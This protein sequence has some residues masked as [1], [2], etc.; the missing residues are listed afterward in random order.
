[1]LNDTNITEERFTP[2]SLHV[3]VFSIVFMGIDIVFSLLTNVLLMMTI[4]NAPSLRTPPNNHL[5]NI[6]VNNILLCFCMILS[7]VSVGTRREDL[8]NVQSFTGFQLFIVSN[9]SLQYLC[10][11]ASICIYRK[12]TIK[13]PSLCLRMRKRM[14]TRSILCGWI[15]SVLLS[16]VFCLSFMPNDDRACD[17][18]NPFQR[19]FRSCDSRK[20][21][22]SEQLVVL[23]I[24]LG[25][26]ITGLVIIFSSYYNI[27]KS[28]NLTGSFGKSRVSPWN[29]NLSLSSDPGTESAEQTQQVNSDS[30][31][32]KPYTISSGNCEDIIVHYQRSEHALTFED[33]FA[34]ENPILASKLKQN[35][36]EKRPLKPTLSNTSTQSTKSKHCTFTDISPDGNLQRIQNIKNASA[37]R[38]Q[39]LRR[40]R[41]SLSSATK[42]SFIMFVAYLVCSLP[43]LVLGI[44]GIL[45]FLS[46]DSRVLTLVVCRLLFYINACF[47]PLW[48][49]LFSKRVRQCLSN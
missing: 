30:D 40:D 14:V 35:V 32:V 16:I 13:R 6:G 10:A 21:F 31:F 46:T 49:L 1:M 48:Y 9:C 38:N 47:Y 7:L 26:Y 4:I 41:I 42:N 44:P 36:F 23:V 28:L 27:C 17:T 20:R 34:L 3:V 12:T 25:I 22:T 11:F 18:L 37:L 39:S 5:L 19:E 15:T 2:L 24:Y 8:V 45:D 33:I 29:R 43:L